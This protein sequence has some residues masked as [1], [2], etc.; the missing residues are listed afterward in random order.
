MSYNYYKSAIA[1]L[2]DEF[3]LSA[4][5]LFN[6]LNSHSNIKYTNYLFEIIDNINKQVDI[7]ELGI[8]RLFFLNNLKFLNYLY[9][10]TLPENISLED[11]KKIIKFYTFLMVE[12]NIDNINLYY[13]NMFFVNY[14]Y[15]DTIIDH[16]CVSNRYKFLYKTKYTEDHLFDISYTLVNHSNLLNQAIIQKIDER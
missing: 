1:I 15:V 8:F 11:F 7:I 12:I 6:L 13:M 3:I 9:V 4:P 10:K 16:D 2:E 14:N 5:N